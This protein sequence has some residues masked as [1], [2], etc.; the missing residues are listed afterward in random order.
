[1]AHIQPQILTQK[2]TLVD[3]DVHL[4]NWLS[5]TW[6][7]FKERGTQILRIYYIFFYFSKK[8]KKRK[9]NKSNLKAFFLKKIL[10]SWGG[11][12]A[13]DRFWL[14]D[15]GPREKTKSLDTAALERNLRA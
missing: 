4:I 8:K 6:S 15:F 7:V 12:G 1:M 14:D 13:V 9:E 2:Q 3:P 10:Y 5:Q 11:G